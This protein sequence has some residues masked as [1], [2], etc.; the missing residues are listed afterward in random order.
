[1]AITKSAKKAL[2][3]SQTRRIRNLRKMSKM[4]DLIKQVRNLV[5]Q[6]KVK[7]DGSSFPASLSHSENS[8]R[9]EAKKLLPQL[10]KSLDKAAKTGLIKK[11]DASRK[12]SRLTKAIFKSQ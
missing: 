9:E 10:Y 4:K 5:L 3:Q 7:E 2:R 11:K 1:M 8:A 12:K 6:N